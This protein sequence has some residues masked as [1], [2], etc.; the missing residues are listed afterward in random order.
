MANN[1]NNLFWTFI[2]GAAA[3]AVLGLLYAPGKGSETRKMIS[4]KSKDLAEDLQD[5]TSRAIDSIND[6]KERVMDVVSEF[7]VTGGVSAALSGL[8]LKGNWNN[9][10]GKLKQRFSELTDKDLTFVEGKEDELI[11]N[12]QKKLGKTK[13]EIIDLIESFTSH[14]SAY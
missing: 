3:G 10:K 11:G 7:S 2:A 8:E 6:L 9:I 14:K 4:D 1:N 12:L 13:D 5:A